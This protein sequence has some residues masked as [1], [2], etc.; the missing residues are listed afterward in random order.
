MTNLITPDHPRAM[1]MLCELDGEEIKRVVAVDQDKQQ[2][3]LFVDARE[4]TYTD[5][6]GN[7]TT[8]YAEPN[9]YGFTFSPRQFKVYDKETGEV[10]AEWNTYNQKGNEQ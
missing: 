10:Y 5:K 1:L 3:T 2:V 8:V 7:S 9:D 6:E 4:F